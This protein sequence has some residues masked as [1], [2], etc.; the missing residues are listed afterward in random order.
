MHHWREIVENGVHEFH[1]DFGGV[2]LTITNWTSPAPGPASCRGE[3]VVCNLP[4]VRETVEL[5]MKSRG[6]SRSSAT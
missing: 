6:P 2:T 3:R 4:I 5:F 1:Q